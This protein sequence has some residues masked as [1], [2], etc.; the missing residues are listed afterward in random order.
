MKY[1]KPSNSTG[2]GP[3]MIC[4][5]ISS[6]QPITGKGGYS[7]IVK[8]RSKIIYKDVVFICVHKCYGQIELMH[9]ILY[10]L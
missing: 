4:N 7:Y 9:P 8:I 2:K 5:F 6:H 10:C 1:A 3:T